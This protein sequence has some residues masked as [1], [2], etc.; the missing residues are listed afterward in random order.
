MSLDAAECKMR[1]SRLDRCVACLTLEVMLRA[2]KREEFWSFCKNI[3]F[4]DAKSLLVGPF[5]VYV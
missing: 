2:K 1:L 5:A 3:H 4:M